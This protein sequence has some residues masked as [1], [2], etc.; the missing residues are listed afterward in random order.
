MARVA[1]NDINPRGDFLGYIMPPDKAEVVTP[2]DTD[3]LEFI[4]RKLRTADGGDITF[5]LAG[6]GTTL[7]ETLTAGGEIVALVK[8]VKATGTTATVIHAYR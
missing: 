7:T 5:V 3:E 6:D 8:Q 1:T 2:S 4:C